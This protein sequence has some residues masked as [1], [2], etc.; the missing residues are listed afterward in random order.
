MSPGSTEI[1]KMG[2]FLEGGLKNSQLSL[3]VRHP[4]LRSS[5]RDFILLSF[6]EYMDDLNP[7]RP[8]KPLSL[9]ITCSLYVTFGADKRV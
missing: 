3:L 9:A 5:S 4:L 2:L 6:F 8:S 1:I 7:K